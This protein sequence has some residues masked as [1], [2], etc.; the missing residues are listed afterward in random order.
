MFYVVTLLWLV[1]LVFVSL[2]AFT[3]LRGGPLKLPFRGGGS[4]T[5]NGKS[6]RIVGAMY[7]FVALTMLAIP[8]VILYASLQ[9][10]R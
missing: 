1:A 7:V 6:A 8:A 5:L 3:G 9:T 10:G 4:M 2:S